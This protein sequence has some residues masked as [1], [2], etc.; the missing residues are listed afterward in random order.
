MSHTWLTVV[1][2]ALG[3]VDENLTATLDGLD[4]DA[5]TH[6]PGPDANP[7]GWLAWHLTRVLDDHLAALA[8]SPQVWEE[9]RDR[10]GLPYS[11]RATGYGQTSAQ[12]GA[13]RAGA[14]DLIGYWTATWERGREILHDLADDDPE[15][16]VDDA[17][18]PPVTLSARLVSLIDEGAQH[19]GQMGYVRGLIGA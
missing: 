3:R 10:F 9:W 1:E 7:I 6:R 13:F 5:L 19:V 2:D 12:V 18:D 4:A 16:V 11:R 17:W 8:G 14:D 15:R